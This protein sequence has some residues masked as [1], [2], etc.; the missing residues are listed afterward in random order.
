MKSKF[1]IEDT[2]RRI[3]IYTSK[4]NSTGRL[5]MSTIRW[6]WINGEMYP[7]CSRC[8]SYPLFLK[9]KFTSCDKHNY[10]ILECSNCGRVYTRKTPPRELRRR[11]ENNWRF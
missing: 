4:T 9:G 7:Q 11:A 6:V 3:P 10:Y 5:K 2:T 1:A 8:G